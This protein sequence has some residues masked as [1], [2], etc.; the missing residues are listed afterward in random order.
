MT[1]VFKLFIDQSLM[2]KKT[3]VEELSRKVKQ[4]A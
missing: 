4:D 3:V 2:N 1:R